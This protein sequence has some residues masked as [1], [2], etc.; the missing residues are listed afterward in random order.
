M[1]EKEVIIGSSKIDA[2][3]RITLT[4]PIPKII[5]AEKGDLIIFK[6]ARLMD[7]FI[8]KCRK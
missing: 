5:G 1:K 3:Y 8:L 2:R 7:E 4:S 6:R